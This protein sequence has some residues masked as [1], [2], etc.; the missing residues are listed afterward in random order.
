LIQE[1]K[2]PRIGEDRF[3]EIKV[4]VKG[5]FFEIFLDDDLTIVRADYDYLSGH[6]GLYARGQLTSGGA[7]SIIWMLE[8]SISGEGSTNR[9]R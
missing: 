6:L 4:L 5:E 1:R 7:N 3:Y 2:L 8:R 9:S